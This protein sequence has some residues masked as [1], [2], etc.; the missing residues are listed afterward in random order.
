MGEKINLP[1]E[2]GRMLKKTKVPTA[3]FDTDVFDKRAVH[4][5][6]STGC[7]EIAYGY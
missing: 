1:F 2:V 3:T 7:W 6:N 4:R 5:A